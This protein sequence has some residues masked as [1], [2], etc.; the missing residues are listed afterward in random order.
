LWGGRGD[1]KSRGII[2]L[3]QMRPR[4]TLMAAP[5]LG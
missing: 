1:G 4:Y 2:F 3:T 5:E